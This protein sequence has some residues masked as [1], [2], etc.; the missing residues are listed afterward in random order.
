MK[1]ANEALVKNALS[2]A[3]SI[4]SNLTPEELGIFM[5]GY[6]AGY[7]E[8][9]EDCSEVLRTALGKAKSFPDKELR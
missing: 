2:G 5:A 3:K 6:R 7:M 4:A 8:C 9:A 1:S